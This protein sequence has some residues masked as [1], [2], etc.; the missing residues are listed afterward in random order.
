MTVWKSLLL[1]LLQGLTEFLPVSSSGHL[2]LL[3]RLL[4]YD[5]QK[6]GVA[7]FVILHAGTLLATLC[8]YYKTIFDLLR[9]LFR[10]LPGALK[11]RG[12]R[13][14]LWDNKKGQ[15]ITFLFIGSIPT[16]IIGYTLED[17]FEKL[18]SNVACVA[19]ALFVTGALLYSTRKIPE[20][21]RGS[22][23][24][25]AGK[26]L[27][28]GTIQGLAITPG[29]SRSGSTISLGM[30]LGLDRRVAAD[31]SFLLS[32]PAIFGALLSRLGDISQSPGKDL[33]PLIMGFLASFMSGYIALLILLKFV[34]RGKFHVFAWYCWTIAIIAG[35]SYLL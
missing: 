33:I 30:W 20:K 8:V 9:Y 35:A 32:I 6:A 26:S 24:I 11:N 7:F 1:G 18:F 19:I 15:L 12:M 29:I 4:Q 25:N 23:K 28:I 2:V 3:D 22:K 17:Q 16:G 34:R 5:P 14:A 10:Q 27:L 13:A 21:L 31:F